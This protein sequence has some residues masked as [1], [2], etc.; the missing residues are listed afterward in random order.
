[1]RGQQCLAGVSAFE[2]LDPLHGRRVSSAAIDGTAAETG[3][4]IAPCAVV[5]DVLDVAVRCSGATP[6]KLR[7][8]AFSASLFVQEAI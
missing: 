6:M 8:P 4:V 5:D 7:S 3:A 1:M 2:L